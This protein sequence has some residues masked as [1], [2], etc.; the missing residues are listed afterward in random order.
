M[1]AVCRY[2]LFGLLLCGW[3]VV[4]A[5]SALVL[6]IDGTIGPVTAEYVHHGLDRAEALEAGVVVLRMDTPG[7]LDVAMRD[8][9]KQILA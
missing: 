5:A 1:I 7:G 2:L 9:I 4:S 3:S 8:V 6:E